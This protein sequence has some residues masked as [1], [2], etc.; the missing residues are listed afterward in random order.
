[1]LEAAHQLS[2]FTRVSSRRSRAK[3]TELDAGTTYTIRSR[4][5]CQGDS[6]VG[7][8]CGPWSVPLTAATKTGVPEKIPLFAG[9][10]TE[11][12]ISVWWRS[13]GNGGNRI[14]YY[15]VWVQ[16]MDAGRLQ[17]EGGPALD[18]ARR[19]PVGARRIP[20]N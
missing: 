12:S 6:D 16:D 9:D 17:G 5:I 3:L 8:L 19:I 1:M 4:V 10:V 14:M 18:H 11:E 13:P 2:T 15:Q 20:R 7:E